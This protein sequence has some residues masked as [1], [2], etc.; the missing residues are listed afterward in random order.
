MKLKIIKTKLYEVNEPSIYSLDNY[1]YH[2]VLT[3]LTC[4]LA[5][6]YYPFV[7]LLFDKNLIAYAHVDVF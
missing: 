3:I 1:I 7:W 4:A 2:F 6:I 5:Y